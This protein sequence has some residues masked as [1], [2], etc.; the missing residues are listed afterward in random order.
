LALVE[1]RFSAHSCFAID[2]ERAQ[3][4]ARANEP[5]SSAS[6]LRLQ[7]F[8]LD[9]EKLGH[10]LLPAIRPTGKTVMKKQVGTL[11]LSPLPF[12]CDKL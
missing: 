12:L 11:I 10:G 3:Q 9:L 4:G 8:L 5:R 7:Y 6:Q 1:S 2:E